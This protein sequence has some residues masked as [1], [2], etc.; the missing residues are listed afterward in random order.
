MPGVGVR[1]VGIIL[2]SSSAPE[3]LYLACRDFD[4]ADSYWAWAEANPEL[5]MTLPTIR[6]RRGFH[7]Y[8]LVDRPVCRVL[9]NGQGELRGVCGLISIAPGSLLADGSGVYEELIP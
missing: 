4:T 6:T 1:G 9:P 5:A 7:V 8:F 3:G 2:G